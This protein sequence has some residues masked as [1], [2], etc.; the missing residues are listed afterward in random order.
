MEAENHKSMEIEKETTANQSEKEEK[1]EKIKKQINEIKDKLGMPIDEGIEEAVIFLNA[2]GLRTT[3]SY[4]IPPEEFIEKPH[5]RKAV[6]PWIDIDSHY[7]QEERWYDN[8]I[9]RQQVIE[10]SNKLKKSRSSY[11]QSSIKIETLIM[12]KC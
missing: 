3:G 4:E 12:I 11:S 7:P 9:L 5:E 10:E 2:L 8:E 1:I 6:Y